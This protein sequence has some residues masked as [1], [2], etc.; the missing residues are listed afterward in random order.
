MTDTNNSGNAGSASNNTPVEGKTS[1][2][3]LKF[4]SPAEI[5]MELRGI[6]KDNTPQQ[7]EESKPKEAEKPEPKE[8]EVSATKTE[9]SEAPVDKQEVV[10]NQEEEL[11]EAQSV[12]NSTEGEGEEAS[13]D[14][15][16][17]APKRALKRIDKLT[18]IK[19]EQAKQLAD[20]QNR[21]KELQERLESYEQRETKPTIDATIAEIDSIQNLEKRKQNILGYIS[22]LETLAIRKPSV[23]EDGNEY[24]DVQGAKLTRD[25]LASALSSF[26]KQIN[27][28]IP[29]RVAEL[30][31]VEQI[32]K[33]TSNAMKAFS[34]YSDANSELK[35]ELDGF[36]S[37]KRYKD[38]FKR[39]PEAEVVFAGYLENEAR[40]SREQ[41]R[42]V[43]VAKKSPPKPTIPT[44]S[45]AAAPKTSDNAISAEYEKLKAKA[46]KSRD[47]KDVVA[48]AEFKSKHKL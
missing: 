14:G 40:R 8:A 13:I 2:D 6:G 10:E 11:D 31:E 12:E 44:A 47:I 48:L 41:S 37:D 7:I 3:S 39:F 15:D 5:Y 27:S 19:N 16:E 21:M 30:S 25:Q 28:D 43:E 34:W 20:V 46:G 42:K 38:I 45:P 29:N 1:N 23:D 17:R 4:K 9:D 32:R 26:K 35:A 36:K 24:W 22:E 18:A 33:N